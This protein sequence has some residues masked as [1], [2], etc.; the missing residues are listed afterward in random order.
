[1]QYPV[2]VDNDCGLKNADAKQGFAQ[3]I[4]DLSK[5]FTPNEWLLSV[6][7]TTNAA[8]IDAT[9]GYDVPQLNRY[10]DWISLMTQDYFSISDSNKTALIAPL[11]ASNGR[12][13]DSTVKYWIQKGA[14][15]EKLILGIPTHGLSFTL[16]NSDD[17][18]L[19]A[20]SNRPGQAG[21][22]TSLPGTLAF[23][24]ICN[25]T[26]H[27]GW[28]VVQSDDTGPYAYHGDQWVSFENVESIHAKAKYIH[29]T[30]LGGAMVWTLD[31]DDFR[32]NCGCGNYP[33]LTALN[34]AMR[35]KDTEPLH[36]C[37]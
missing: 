14:A 29:N 11:H 21:P 19:G 37:V 10:C 32:G 27:N 34:Q 5:A 22:F 20:P 13:I 7:V 28:S 24:E 31:F 6:S 1:M 9:A 16:E 18:E 4:R 36:H 8:A 30:N 25:N 12:D 15:P 2:C 23:Y 33:L 26:Q 35:D 17:H 3:L